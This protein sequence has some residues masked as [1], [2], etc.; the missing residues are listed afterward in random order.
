MNS[1][2]PNKVLGVD[3]FLELRQE[4]LQELKQSETP[5]NLL[6]AV[7]APGDEAEAPPG[8]EPTDVAVEAVVCSYSF[9]SHESSQY[10]NIYAVGPL[11]TG[12]L[13]KITCCENRN[14]NYQS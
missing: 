6:D 1:N 13:G 12:L 14:F 3:E 10:C 5:L 11:I 2:A 9:I 7:S 4:V 8:E